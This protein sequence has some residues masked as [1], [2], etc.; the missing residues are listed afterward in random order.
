MK[1]VWYRDADQSRQ[2]KLYLQNRLQEL[3]PLREQVI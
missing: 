3:K 1:Y 2:F